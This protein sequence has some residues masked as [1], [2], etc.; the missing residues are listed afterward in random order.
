[1]EETTHSHGTNW[2]ALQKNA[3]RFFFLFLGTTSFTAYNV[4]VT[5][6]NIP[7]EAQTKYMSIFSGPVAWLD[8]HFYHFGFDPK[9]HLIFLGDGPFGWAFLLTLFFVCIAGA[10]IWSMLDRQRKNYNRLHY[11]FRT[12]LA[13]YL[14]L[15]M[16]IY[17]VEKIIPVQMPYPNVEDLLTPVGDLNGFSLVWDFIGSNKGY[18]IFTGTCEL[19]AS[20]LILFRRTRVFG[21]LFM[22]T[23]LV[24][25]VCLNVFYNIMVKLLCMQLLLTTLFLLAPYVPRLVRFFYDL[26][27]VSLAEKTYAFSTPWKKWVIILLCIAPA[28]V[29]YGIARKSIIRYRHNALT[30]KNQKLYN[31]EI[32]VRGTDTLPPLQTDTLRW[33]RFVMTPYRDH[34]MAVIY[35]MNDEKDFYEY[36]IDSNRNTITLHDNPDT[37]TWH[38]FK[39]GYPKQGKYQ[40]MGKWKGQPVSVTMNDIAIDSLFL[41]NKEKV[42]WVHNF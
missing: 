8:H 40:L 11:W 24:N 33:K 38:I 35:S 19:V 25:V 15:T 3:F 30:L 9:K 22:T 29:T 1:M 42:T 21:S 26:K 7:W 23:V 6:F 36:D 32:F 4:L 5:V 37:A 16:V 34:K 39:Y 20:I 12:Y 27:P 18:S 2:T 31:T 13:Y 28:W 17:A 41:L 14:F 10:I